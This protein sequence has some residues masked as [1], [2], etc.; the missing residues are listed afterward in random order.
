MSEPTTAT[1]AIEFLVEL[2]KEVNPAVG[3]E[4]D[5]IVEVLREDQEE[6]RRLRKEIIARVAG[7]RAV[8]AIKDATLAGHEAAMRL[9]LADCTDPGGCASCETLRAR[10]VKP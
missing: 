2:K 1:K 5:A 7:L 4:L 10:L 9:V 8:I 6:I 3:E